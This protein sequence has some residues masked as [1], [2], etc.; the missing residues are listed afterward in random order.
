MASMSIAEQRR[1]ATEIELIG[2]QRRL[3]DA[4]LAEYDSLAHRSYMR[5]WRA[6]QAE[7]H[8]KGRAA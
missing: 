3:T 7:K 6:Q 8:G 5:H 4:E 2:G 1:R